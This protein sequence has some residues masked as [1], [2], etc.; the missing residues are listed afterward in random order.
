METAPLNA[1][2]LSAYCRRHGLYPGNPLPKELPR[3]AG[4]IDIADE[5]KMCDC[6][7]GRLHE[8][9]RESSEQLEFIPAQVK[10]VETVRQKYS[11]R[12]CE[13]DYAQ[14]GV[15]IAPVPA[16]SYMI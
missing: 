9:V 14:A 1:T 4:V 3:E 11:C 2:E 10:V 15:K 5:D 8:M 16:S 7:N 13:K 6:C 12:A